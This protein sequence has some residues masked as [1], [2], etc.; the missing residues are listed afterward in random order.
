[1]IGGDWRVKSNCEISQI[2]CQWESLVS[3]TGIDILNLNKIFGPPIAPQ[4][5]M[6]W[7]QPWSR[8]EVPWVFK[9]KS[10]G[11]G[12]EVLLRS[13]DLP[14]HSRAR[15][16]KLT[17]V[18]RHPSVDA[19]KPNVRVRVR[20]GVVQVD[21]E[22]ARVHSI[23]PVA[24][25]ING[26]GEGRRVDLNLDLSLEKFLPGI[27]RSDHLLKLAIRSSSTAQAI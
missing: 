24:P 19:T 15:C 2:W 1:M 11:R 26:P 27:K 16:M 22:H 13:A 5:R 6:R 8:F 4:K 14:D 23:V 10:L 18:S 20:R 12:D 7:D 25:T 3:S 17:Q 9:R 21:R